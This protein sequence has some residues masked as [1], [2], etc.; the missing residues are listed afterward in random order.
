MGFKDWLFGSAPPAPP[1][2]D[3]TSTDPDMLARVAIEYTRD[4]MTPHGALSKLIDLNDQS[5][6]TRVAL[7]SATDSVRASAV[8]RIKDPAILANIA[9][10]DPWYGVRVSATGRVT[11][12]RVLTS[13]AAK[14][15]DEQVRHA[16]ASG[17]TCPG[18]R[19]AFCLARKVKAGFYS[20]EA[21]L[22]S[23]A[24]TP[25]RCRGCNVLM[26]MGCVRN[27]AC[28][29]CRGIVFDA[30]ADVLLD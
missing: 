15:P 10:A 5:L 7:E 19:R 13:I 25:Y 2:L 29:A 1:K 9:I 26:C 16:A 22:D 17:L 3:L 18:C 23:V 27:K 4:G 14:D 8:C 21:L 24:R 28:P 11:D 12:E 20:G 30:A 6:L